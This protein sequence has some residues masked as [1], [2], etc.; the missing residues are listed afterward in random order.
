MGDVLELCEVS[1]N[2]SLVGGRVRFRFQAG[3]QIRYFGKIGSFP[4]LVSGAESRSLLKEKKYPPRKSFGLKNSF[5][6]ALFVKRL[7]VSF[8]K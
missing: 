7:F 4:R 5:R 1:L 2:Y 6:I 8:I 3:L